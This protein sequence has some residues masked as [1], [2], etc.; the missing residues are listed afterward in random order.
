MGWWFGTRLACGLLAGRRPGTLR[1][2]S[3]AAPRTNGG[4]CMYAQTMSVSDM[5]GSAAWATAAA[6]A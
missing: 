6:L 2:T 5:A 3:L 4:T 1:P